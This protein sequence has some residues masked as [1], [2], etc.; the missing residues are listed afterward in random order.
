MK[1]AMISWFLSQKQRQQKK[2]IDKWDDTKLK[3][4]CAAK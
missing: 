1:W 2:T 3:S 4:F